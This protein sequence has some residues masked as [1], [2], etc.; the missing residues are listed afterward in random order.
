[1][2]NSQIC[3]LVTE[4]GQSGSLRNASPYHGPGPCHGHTVCRWLRGA[5]QKMA[6]QH[7]QCKA[8]EAAK[9]AQLSP[10]FFLPCMFDGT[11]S[12]C[13]KYRFCVTTN[14]KR[15]PAWRTP[16]GRNRGLHWWLDL[17][18]ISMSHTWYKHI[19]TYMYIYIYIYIWLLGL[20]ILHRTSRGIWWRHVWVR[21]GGS[22]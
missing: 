9:L 22:D 6:Q 18:I 1:M 5:V 15:N 10:S 13:K 11:Q 2:A 16:T 8:N 19:Y 3:M 12:F 20:S 7:G 4:A 17:H 14:N 21:M